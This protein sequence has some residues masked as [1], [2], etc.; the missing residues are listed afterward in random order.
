L[1]AVVLVHSSIFI[2]QN[3]IHSDI[4]MIITD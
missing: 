3:R 1:I 4:I 2:L